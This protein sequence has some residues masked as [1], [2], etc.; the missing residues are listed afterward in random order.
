MRM[1]SATQVIRC[2]MNSNPLIPAETKPAF[3]DDDIRD[4][5]FHLY[6]QSGCEPGRDLDNW[7]EAKACLTANI[8]KD[9]SRSRLH[10]HF[11]PEDSEVAM[12]LARDD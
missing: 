5:A 12:M 9:Q 11:H 3:T 2:G 7:L 8:S 6:Q 10:R 4:Y 1:M